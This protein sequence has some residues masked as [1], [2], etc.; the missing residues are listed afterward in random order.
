[1]VLTD[2]FCADVTCNRKGDCNVLVH[3]YATRSVG[4]GRTWHGPR[5]VDVEGLKANGPYR[6]GTGATN[7][8]AMPERPMAGTESMASAY[9]G[10]AAGGRH[11]H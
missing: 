5:P 6:R 8:A 2:L 7:G 4:G 11:H 9:R 3:K 1:V 10:G